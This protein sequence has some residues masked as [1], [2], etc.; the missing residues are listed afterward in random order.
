MSD[1][2]VEGF[3]NTFQIMIKT[4]YMKLSVNKILRQTNRHR[5]NK[6]TDKKTDSHTNKWTD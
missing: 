3:I 4:Y 6:H 5:S 1:F 2:S